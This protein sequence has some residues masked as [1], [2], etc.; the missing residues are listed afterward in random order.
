[1]LL[2]K[3]LLDSQWYL[4]T[5]TLEAS[6]IDFSQFYQAGQMALSPQSHH[7][8]EPL[9]QKCWAD[10]LT[11]PYV[12][13]KNFYNQSVPFLYVIGIPFGLLPY[14]KAYVLWCLWWEVLCVSLLNIFLE[15]HSRLNNLDRTLLLSGV[16]ASIPAYLCVWHGQT[17]F[18]LLACLILF[19][20]FL[21]EGKSAAAGL[22]FAIATF[23]PQYSLPFA[24]ALLG[25]RALKVLLYSAI[26]EMVLMAI[27]AI[28]L[29]L[30]NIIGYPQVL[31]HAENSEK[32]IGVNPSIMVS[33]RG[34][35]SVVLPHKTAMNCTLAVLA[36]SLPTWSFCAYKLKLN[37]EN[38]KS[39]IGRW[40]IAL[41]F[42]LALIV[43]PHSH[44]FDCLLLAVPAALTLPCIDLGIIWAGKVEDRGN[45]K[46][47]SLAH[48]IWCSI[49][50]FY[51]LISWPINFVC[52]PGNGR[53]LEGFCFLVLN[54][55]LL[56]CGCFTLRKLATA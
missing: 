56:L 38:F 5:S 3:P 50:I 45:T 20:H 46:R 22:F 24:S 31:L 8:Y 21:L 27:A 37:I 42:V 25:A 36:L 28:F 40:S 15:K 48:Q 23:K 41:T 55:A 6:L 54:S 13:D 39:E 12:L 29:G 18:L 44:F 49:L 33:I 32:F 34:V 52:G 26:F 47:L 4:H 2:A 53:E 11:F 14:G 16:L 19:T 9:V 1:M 30:E 51:P 43:S 35:L 17:T 7:I 10:G